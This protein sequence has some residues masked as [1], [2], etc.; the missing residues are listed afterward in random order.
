MISFFKS[1]KAS[2]PQK[3]GIKNE[4]RQEAVSCYAMIMLPLIGFVF[5]HV[6]PVFWTFRWSFFAY[7][8]VPSQTRFIGFEN[9]K[10]MFTTDTT[11]WHV[12]GNTL[13]ITLSKIPIE[14]SLAMI[15][16]LF[17]NKRYKGSGFFQAMYY[18]PNIISITII[19]LIASNM[20]SYRGLFN[21]L[22]VKLGLIDVPIDWFSKKGTAIAMI[23][24]T[25]VW[26]TFGVNVMYILSALSNVP[27][28]LYE[29]AKLDGASK[30]VTFSR[31]TIPMIMPVFQVILLMSLVSTLSMNE[32]VIILTGGG[33][34]GSTNTVMSYLYTK[35]VPGFATDA[36][37]PLGY[38]CAMSLITTLIFMII[39]VGY[40]KL[41]KM[42]KEMY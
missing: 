20:F 23:V 1:K 22:F 4:L 3:R 18:L 24:I 40:N 16:A 17:L 14:I 21:D 12:W 5:L 38:G 19:G 29:C 7:N 15:L 31:I 25:S 28:E 36:Q 42:L 30:W 9:F 32:L 6:Y 8:G 41:S 26:N 10:T 39:A 2:T 13:L 11:Y 37:P 27:D 34:Y 35:F 33:P